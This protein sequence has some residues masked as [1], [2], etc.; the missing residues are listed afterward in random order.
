MGWDGGVQDVPALMDHSQRRAE[1]TPAEHRQMDLQT[2][3]EEPS[4]VGLK[5]SGPPTPE[6]VQVHEAGQQGPK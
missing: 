5:A 2:S 6:P 4:A 3:E 1:G